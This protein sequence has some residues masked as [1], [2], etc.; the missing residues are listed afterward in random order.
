MTLNWCTRAGPVSGD[1]A[2]RQ[3]IM[4]SVSLCTSHSKI[5]IGVAIDAS[6]NTAVISPD[7]PA[8]RAA[9]LIASWFF[10]ETAFDFWKDL[11]Q[12]FAVDATRLF[13]TI[14]LQQIILTTGKKSYPMLPGTG[15]NLPDELSLRWQFWFLQ[16]KIWL[17]PVQVTF[18]FFIVIDKTEIASPRGVFQFGCQR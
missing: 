17:M 3:G 16:F 18:R 9:A 15:C 14:N 7:I 13:Y 12:K 5:C 4:C 6:E 1:Q 10:R 2:R 11:L 8:D